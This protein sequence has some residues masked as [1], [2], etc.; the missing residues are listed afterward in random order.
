[1]LGLLKSDFREFASALS[2]ETSIL[3]DEMAYAK[4]DVGVAFSSVLQSSTDNVKELIGSVHASSLQEAKAEALLRVCLQSV[5]TS[6][7]SDQDESELGPFLATFDVDKLEDE[8]SAKLDQNPELNI[9][10]QELV[11][12]VV[13]YEDFWCRH[14]FR[15]SPERIHRIWNANNVLSTL[16]NKLV[17]TVPSIDD[18]DGDF[19]NESFQLLPHNSGKKPLS[20]SSSTNSVLTTE[21]DDSEATFKDDENHFVSNRLSF[22][23]RGSS[24]SIGSLQSETL[25]VDVVQ[26]STSPQN[27]I[28]STDEKSIGIL[29]SDCLHG[30][31]SVVGMY[32]NGESDNTVAKIIGEFS[33]REDGGVRE[34]QSEALHS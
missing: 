26:T 13:T 7:F 19:C 14:F 34:A 17:R 1:M 6:S 3:L 32:V 22:F 33:S 8:I 28:T 16:T 2:A 15:C 10:F 24:D 21:H 12:S 23:R 30:R 5:Y 27:R 31:N 11:P 9:F 29:Q 18:D 20:R 25:S 4:E